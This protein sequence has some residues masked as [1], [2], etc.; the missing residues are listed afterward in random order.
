VAIDEVEIL[1]HCIDL[2]VK[3]GG[4]VDDF[5]D[6]CFTPDGGFG[7][8]NLLATNFGHVLVQPGLLRNAP[9]RHELQ[10]KLSLA[11]NGCVKRPSVPAFLNEGYAW[12]V[13]F[14]G[15][16][17]LVTTADTAPELR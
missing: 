4:K 10:S 1:R 16:P 13:P 3:F 5:V 9:G 17:K 7:Q 12:G 8:V 6:E 14:D 11:L 15:P 2:I